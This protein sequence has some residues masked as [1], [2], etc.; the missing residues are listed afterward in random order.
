MNYTIVGMF[1]EKNE[2]ITASKKLCNDGFNDSQIDVSHFKTKGDY[3]DNDYHYE[4]EK[5]TSG[6]WDWLFGDDNDEIRDRH[7]RVGARTN[8]LSVYAKDR[9]EAEKATRIM[10]NCGAVD[11]DEYDKSLRENKAYKANTDDSSESIKVMKED[12][13]VGKREEK[14]GGVS[15]KSRIIEKPVKEDI[16]LRKERVYVTRKPMD[17]KVSGDKAFQDKTIA[18]TETAEKAVVGKS[19]RVVEEIS[20]NK[21]VKQKDKTIKDTVRE[22]KVDIDKNVDKKKKTEKSTF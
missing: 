21:D 17:K 3:K 16:R 7:S 18:M 15:I 8:I 9:K 6:F 10:D 1:N 4:E 19:T 14:T 11:V 13:S 12:I 2:A 22:T 5:E 20:L